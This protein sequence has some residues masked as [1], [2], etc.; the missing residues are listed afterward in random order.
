MAQQDNEAEIYAKG[1]AAA[2]EA[3]QLGRL[4][5]KL[6]RIMIDA[7]SSDEA[8]MERR[9]PGLGRE[10]LSRAYDDAVRDIV[11]AGAFDIEASDRAERR[12]EGVDELARR[13]GLPAD[14]VAALL[15]GRT[16][17]A[18]DLDDLDRLNGI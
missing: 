7:V 8:V 17:S 4:E 16:R 6:A 14:R 18:A 9:F 5:P 1:L 13:S 15:S 12:R 3:G 11:A 2:A 10:G